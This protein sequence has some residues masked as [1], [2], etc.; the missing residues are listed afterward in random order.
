MRETKI[1]DD[2]IIRTR[3]H[4]VKVDHD[5]VH[6]NVRWLAQVILG[7]CSPAWSLDPIDGDGAIVDRGGDEYLD[8]LA[9]VEA[10][11]GASRSEA[12]PDRQLPGRRRSA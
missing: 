11:L 7:N 9:N 10:A 4:Q 1:M 8:L 12:R 3:N 6:V 5:S 2:R